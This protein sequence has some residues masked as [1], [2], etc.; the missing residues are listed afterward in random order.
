MA[1]QR[2]NKAKVNQKKIQENLKFVT[3]VTKPVIC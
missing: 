2:A 3:S 1:L